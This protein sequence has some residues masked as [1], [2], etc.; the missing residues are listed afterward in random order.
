EDGQ[1]HRPAII[2]RA[3][4]GSTERFLGVL[5]EHY[6]GAFPVWLSPVQAM[7]IPISDEKHGEYAQRVL[8][9]LQAAGLRAEVDSRKERMNAKV[10]DAQLRKIPYMLVVGDKEA[11]AGTVALRLR[12]NENLG[13]IPLD[14]FIARAAAVKV[15]RSVDLWPA[16]TA[17]SN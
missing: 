11:E 1:P 16:V 8:E 2:H 12:S 3:I 13:A 6:A 7:V 17:A 14:E 5:I 15:S 9:R 4:M 10:R